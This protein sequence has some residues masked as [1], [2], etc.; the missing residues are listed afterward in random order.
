MLNFGSKVAYVLKRQ[1]ICGRLYRIQMKNTTISYL[2]GIVLITYAFYATSALAQHSTRVQRALTMLE[3]GD[4]E[5][6][7]TEAQGAINGNAKD[8]EAHAVLGI[9]YLE[10]GNMVEAEKAIGRAFDLERKNGLVR[11]SRGKLFGKKG[12]IKDALEEF[13]LAIKYDKNDLDSY[14]ALSRF[15]LSVDSLK[16]AE[17]NLYR[18]QTANPNDPRPYIGL[19]ELYEKQRVFD[20]AIKQLEDAI[21]LNAQ[22]VT[23]RAK[24]AQLYF[25]RRNY[26]K[27]INEWIE[28][29]RIDST[30]NRGYYEIANLFFIGSQYA[31]AAGFAEK[32]IQVEPND[33][34]GHWL[35]AQALVENN[36][37]TKALKSLE[38]IAEH[39]DSLRPYTELFRA[40]GYLFNKEFDKANEIYSRSKKLSPRDLEDWGTSLYY[41]GDTLAGVE[42][43]KESLVGDT[44]RTDSAKSLTKLRITALYQS[45]RRFELA[46]KFLEQLAIQE[47]SDSNYVKAGQ[48][49]MAGGL[50]AE[51]DSA[52]ARALA[53][54]A[55][56]F[57]ALIGLIDLQAKRGDEAAIRKNYDL[58]AS[59]AQTVWHKNT[60]G[61]ALGRV[62]FKFFADKEYK[63]SV[64]WFSASSSLLSRESK[65]LFN[66]YYAWGAALIQLKQNDK[67][68]EML[69]KA[70]ALDPNHEEVKKNLKYLDELKAAPNE[71]K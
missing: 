61:E 51:A 52:F 70:K 4:L 48:F 9:A 33:V 13:A 25:R 69:L 64:D 68:R 44:V 65:Y 56:S 18:A 31:N 39:S 22:D 30:Y 29:M 36:E 10:Q 49:Y 2:I 71:K 66:V 47:Q 27:S 7:I 8:H 54:N 57:M 1:L 40:R 11:M 41:S 19:A 42:K 32:Y 59:Q 28:L 15:Y 63:R 62:A 17:I 53:R 45:M 14:L 67:A 58:A 50:Q 5:A 60:L 21:K 43:W 34:K 23:A 46:G 37:P 3:F 35:Y 16:A 6:A 12:E 20:L 55:N 24:L 26:T 38:F